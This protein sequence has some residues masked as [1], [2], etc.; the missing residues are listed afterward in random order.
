[1]E[2]MTQIDDDKVTQE[3]GKKREREEETIESLQKENQKLKKDVKYYKMV[4]EGAL[5][6]NEKERQKCEQLEV[7]VMRYKEFIAR[8]MKG[9]THV[10]DEEEIRKQY[11]VDD[12][13]S[14][15]LKP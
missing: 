4:L 2:I 5:N 3:V 6:M 14:Y 13:S 7:Q 11:H 1:M 10:P 9:L 8:V 15:Y 12:E